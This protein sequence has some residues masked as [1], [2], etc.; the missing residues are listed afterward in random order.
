MPN[1][2][3]LSIQG[4]GSRKQLSDALKLL[5]NALHSDDIDEIYNINGAAYNDHCIEVTLTNRESE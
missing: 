1:D 2:L 4:T 3:E 5:A